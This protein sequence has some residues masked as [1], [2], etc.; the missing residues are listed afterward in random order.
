MDRGTSE[1]PGSE[2]KG[3]RQKLHL[4]R[5]AIQTNMSSPGPGLRLERPKARGAFV[6]QPAVEKI[7]A[8]RG[9]RG[10]MKKSNFN[11]ELLASLFGVGYWQGKTRG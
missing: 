7:C 1:T 5:A 9:P 11:R 2:S 4:A 6:R 10:Q 3:G 8:V